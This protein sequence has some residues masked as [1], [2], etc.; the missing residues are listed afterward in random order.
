MESAVITREVLFVFA[1]LSIAT[2]G[3]TGVTVT[4]VHIVSD[5]KLVSIRTKGLLYTSILAFIG[6]VAP[7]SGI[8]AKFVSIALVLGVT[9]CSILC[10][11]FCV[12]IGG[13]HANHA[14]V[15]PVNLSLIGAS[16]WLGWVLFFDTTHVMRPYLL[17]I[18][19]LLI[20]A[21]ILFI[22][23]ILSIDDSNDL[24]CKPE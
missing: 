14:L 13:R 24:D 5:K 2:L 15:W 9:T 8:P 22:R 7:L 18:G 21:V 6:S 16:F 1:Q 20:S 3:F 19:L 4:F 23:L 12:K 11:F 10:L 17:L